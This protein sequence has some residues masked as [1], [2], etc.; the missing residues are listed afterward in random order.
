[1]DISRPK[2]YIPD[3]AKINLNIEPLSPPKV[4]YEKRKFILD[5]DKVKEIIKG[6]Y[7]E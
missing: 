6:K 7:G 5:R 2:V 3:N 4:E 1:M